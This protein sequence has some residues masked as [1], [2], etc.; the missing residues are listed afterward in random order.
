MSESRGFREESLVHISMPTISFVRLGACN[1]SKSKLLNEVLSCAQ[2]HHHFFVHRDMECGNVSREISDGLVEISWYFPA[3]RE[4]SD[5]FPE[6]VAITN[7]RGDVESHWLQFR[8][9]T[10]FSTA[11]FIITE[12]ISDKEYNLLSTLPRLPSK[13]YFVLNVESGKSKETLGFLNKLAPV[14][15]LNKSQLLVK[16]K[17][18]NTTDFVKKLRSAM[19]HI[20]NCHQKVVTMEEM[21]NVSQ[22][23]GIQI[24]EEKE[25][26]RNGALHAKEIVEEIKNIVNYKKEMLKLQGDLWRNLAKVEKELCRMKGQ[27]DTPT[28]DYK[29]QLQEKWISLRAQQNQCDLTNAIVKF[30]NGI[31]HLPPVEKHHF[32]KWMKFSLDCV[33]RANLSQLREEYKEKCHIAGSDPR[34]LAQLDLTIATSSLGVEHFMRELGQFYEAEYTMVREGNMMEDQRQFVHLPRIAA[35]L[36][37]EGF[38]MELIDGDASNIPLQWVTDVLTE[39]HVKVGGKSRMQVITVLGVQSTGKSTLLNTMFGLQFAVSSGRCTRGAFMTLLRVTEDFQEELG[40][41]FVLVI[42]TEGLKAPELAKLED[43][44]EHDNELATLVIGLSDITIVNLAMENATEMKDIL[45]IVVHAFLRME[46]IGHKPNCQ[47]VHQNVSDVSAHDQNMRDRKHLLEQLNAMTK[48]AA[49]ME[50]QRRE[51]CFTDIMDYD[52]EKHNWYI[53]GL[54]HG[55]PP[56]APVNLGYS[57]SVSDLKRYLFEFMSPCSQNRPPKDIPQFVSWVQSLWNAVKHENFIFSFRN[58]L[59]AGAYNQLSVKYSEWEWEFRKEMHLW[60]SKADTI[61]QNQSLEEIESD[62]LSKLTLEAQQKLHIGEQTMSENI[63][64][65]FESG[66][67]SLHLIEKYKEDFLRSAKFLRNQLEGY[68]VK[69]CEEA[70]LIRKGQ[71]KIALM[72]AGYL[73]TIEGKVRKLLEECRERK[74]DLQPEELKEEFAK[75]WKETLEELPVNSLTPHKIHPIVFCH[76]Q[77]DLEHRG[78]LASQI[79]QKF[80]HFPACQ[81]TTFIMKEKYIEKSVIRKLTGML[82]FLGVFRDYLAEA[83]E[84]AMSLVG[85]CMSYVTE[86]INTNMDYDETYSRELLKM[87]N[88]RIKES[89]FQNL[90]PTVHFEV[91]LKCYILGKAADSFQKMHDDFCK[92]HNPH[93]RLERLKPQ[94]FSIFK[95]LYYAKDACQKRAKYFCEVCLKPA[96]VEHLNKRLGIAMV[97]DLLSSPQSMQ[98]GSRSFFQFTV[99]KTLLEEKNF[100]EYVKYINNYETFVKFWIQARLMEYYEQRE[101]LAALER[102]TLSSVVKKTKDTLEGLADQHA[103]LPEFLEAFCQEMSDKLVLS[104]DSLDVTLFNNTAKAASFSTEA[105]AY[106]PEMMEDILSMQLKLDVE[107]VFSNILFKPQ[108]EIFKRVFGCGKQCPFCKVPCEAGGGRHR[109]HFASI[110]RPQGLG[111]VRNYETKA[112][113]YSLC[114]SDVV[115]NARFRNRDTGEQ[116]HPY[117]EYRQYYPKWCI[118][119]DP[120]ITASDYWKFVF[121]K[122]NQQFAERYHAVPADLPNHWRRITQE[123]ALKSIQDMFN[124][125]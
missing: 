11:V 17:S 97:D 87:I 33:A 59:V 118:Q 91:N 49:R 81:K 105:Q 4:N 61:I 120:S 21:A 52:P 98:Y 104:K 79:F 56:M 99:L 8:F 90:H 36:M 111:K 114:S 57:E 72:Q 37:L 125:E 51:I 96:M 73:K 115:S 124:M 15:N 123:Q 10:K 100:E 34:Q 88:E 14:L 35:E 5:L 89:N 50:K 53:P 30:I 116:W 66:G 75:M 117:K 28:E 84:Q 93:Q 31:H 112:L 43:S 64:S 76:L 82:N 121:K 68:A 83:E 6:P 55:V 13:Y 106:L 70:V 80:S 108:D 23:L 62:A 63:L 32:L 46:E 3:G 74:L 95:D 16:E 67:E 77:K 58:S 85:L 48:A 22:E 60:V 45:Q 54:W 7:L 65:Y 18:Q 119:P 101:S 38:P 113:V 107:T 42:D 40:C 39:L 27:G 26:C 2:H 24:D 44:Y 12:N 102:E 25:D 110:H 86:K 69:K 71:K 19:K 122:F 20:V 41:D 1:L 78:S 92:A 47:F 109:E 94:Y 29:S 9:L 103:T